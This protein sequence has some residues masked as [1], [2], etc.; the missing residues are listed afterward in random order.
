M[1]PE[2]KI[3]DIY[4]HATLGPFTVVV[5]APYMLTLHGGDANV[6]WTWQG[7]AAE[8]RTS[9]FISDAELTETGGDPLASGNPRL[10]VPDTAH[11]RTVAIREACREILRAARE[12][13]DAIE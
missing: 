13:R 6:L 4:H 7:T 5:P 9:G 2:I 12:I 10:V 8:L 11:A 1:T 3:G